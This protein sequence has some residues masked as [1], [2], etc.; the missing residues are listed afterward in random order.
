M[1]AMKEAES[2]KDDLLGLLLLESSI[3]RSAKDNTPFCTFFKIRI[4]GQRVCSHVL[5]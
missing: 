1:Q 3:A 4:L 5:Q 2:A